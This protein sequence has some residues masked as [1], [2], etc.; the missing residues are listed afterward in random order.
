MYYRV[1]H[2][3]TRMR[4]IVAGVLPSRIRTASGVGNFLQLYKVFLRKPWYKELELSWVGDFNPKMMFY[5]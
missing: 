4:A 5:L 3:M 1:S 2:E